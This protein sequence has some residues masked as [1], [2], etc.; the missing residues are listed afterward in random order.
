MN[1]SPYLTKSRFKTA[2]ECITKLYYTGKKKEY[3]DENLIDPFIQSLAKGGFQVGELAKFYFSD[4]PVRDDITIYSKDFEDSLNETSKRLQLD[5]RV[6]IAEAAFRFNNLFVRTDIVVKDGHNLYL[7][8]VKAKSV[9]TDDSFTNAK[10]NGI[11]KKWSSYLYDL[12][13]QKYVIENSELGKRFNVIPHLMMVDKD[14]TTNIDGLNQFFKIIRESKNESFRVLI[15]EGLNRS[16]LGLKILREVELTDVVDRIIN[17]FNVPVDYSANMSFVDFVNWASKIYTNDEQVFVQIGVKCKDCQFN[18]SSNLLKNGFT[19]CW[20]NQTGYSDELLERP[21]VLELWGGKAGQSSPV[22]KL[23]DNGIYLLQ[24]ARED[25]IAPKSSN[26]NN[27]QESGLTALERRMMQ[28]NLVKNSSS[29]SYFDKEG[30][31]EESSSWTYPLHMIDFETSM[32]ALPFHKGTNPYQ[33]IA[34]QFSHHVLHKDGKVEHIGEFIADEV[35]VFPNFDFVRSLK[36][37]LE[38]DNGTIFRYHNHENNFLNLIVQQLQDSPNSPDDSGE[39]IDFIRSITK[40]KIDDRVIE[41][42]RNM[43]DLYELVLKY[44]YSPFAKGS[45]S[46]KQILPSIINDSIFLRNKYGQKG[47][48]GKNLTVKSLNFEDHI[49]ISEQTSNNP[50]KTLPRVFDGYDNEKLD[51]LLSD[52]DSLGDGGAALTA[53]S[54]LQF[55][56]VEKEQRIKI[57]EALLRYCELDTMAMIMLMEGWFNWREIK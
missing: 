6:V 22:Q 16:N 32:V 13:F 21:L 40:Y 38:K 52:F 24:N 26:N 46:L 49:W 47:I 23:I 36:Q 31:I 9:S 45:N 2:L 41:G 1:R 8:E 12:A 34:F 17:E 5:G 33:G 43:V 28:V 4:N 55:S 51:A 57:K 20:K 50:Y 27:N 11:D 25:V 30:F 29:S 56:E 19:E 15:P 53:Y 48:Y 44:Y 18:S 7:Y 37:Q 39:L 42:E 3:A 14:S 35:G 54:F 10:N